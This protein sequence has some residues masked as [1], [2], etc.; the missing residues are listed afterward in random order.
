MNGTQKL[1]VGLASAALVLILAGN[2]RGANRSMAQGTLAPE[3]PTH[4][5]HVTAAA[6]PALQAQDQPVVLDFWAPWC[7]PCRTQGPILERFATLAG[8]RAVVAKVNVDDERAL[9]ARYE[10][11]AIPTLIIMKHG[12]VVQRLVGVQSAEALLQALDAKN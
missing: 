8:E 2:L 4:I 6:F 12:A 7:G 11:R 9:A 3:G 10:V 5:V 1:A